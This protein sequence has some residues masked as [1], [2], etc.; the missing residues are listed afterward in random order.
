AGFFDPS[1][2]NPPPSEFLN[3]PFQITFSLQFF[4]KFFLFLL[5]AIIGVSVHRDFKSKVFSILYSFPIQKRDYLLGKFL[6]AFTL[7][8][9][10]TLL[11]G[12]AL[13]IGEHLP[14][15]HAH[16][17]GD[18]RFAGYAQAF[19]VYVLPNMFVYG[20]GVFAVVLLFRNIYAG[21]VSVLLL[22]FLQI[23]TENAF[24][25]KPLLVG[26]LDPFAQNA[27]AYATQFWTLEEKNAQLIP[28]L[29]VVLY[30]RLLW[31]G[32]AIILGGLTYRK[33]E[34]HQHAI[35]TFQINRKS[36]KETTAANATPTNTELT[37]LQQD[38]SFLQQLKNTWRL[39]NFHFYAIVRNWM[40][41]V[42][43]L[44]GLLAVIFALA[45]VTNTG[46]MVLLPLTRIMLAIPAFFFSTIIIL[47]TFVYSGMLVHKDRN[48]EMNQLVDTC[49][50]PN[51]TIFSAHLLAIIKMQIVLLLVML[52]AGIALQIYN[53]YYHFELGLY[54]FHLFVLTFLGLLIWAF[55][56]FFVHH[57]LPNPYLDI[58]LLILAWLGSTALPE[59]GIETKLLAFNA[60]EVL[61]YSDLDGYGNLL[62][63]F[64]LV[65]SYWLVFGLILLLVTYLLYKRGQLFSFKERLFI[66]KT[67]LQRPVQA[68]FATIFL[69]FLTLGF[70][71][72]K[73]EAQLPNTKVENAY[74]Q[75]FE[76]DFETFDGIV[77]PKITDIQL[78]VNL[79]PASNRFDAKGTYT[80]VNKS[81]KAIDTLLLKTGFDETTTFEFDRNHQRIAEDEYVHFYVLKLAEPLQPNDSLRFQFLMQS[82][83][84]NLFQRNSDILNNG[85]FLRYDVFPR[86]GYFLAADDT[87]PEDSLVAR[88]NVQS[89]AAHLVNFETT[90][91]T[92]ADQI[93]IAPGYLQREWS[94]DNRRYF[95]YRT[96]QPIKFLFCLLSGE[97]TVQKETWKGTNLAVYYHPNH[98]Q[99][100]ANMIAGLKAAIDY[101]SQYFSDFQHR[102]ARII[103][104]AQSEGTLATTMANL[105]PMSEIRF[106]ANT[107][108]NSGKIDLA[109]YVTAH[110]LTHQWWGNQVLPARAAGASMLTESI[111]E[112]ITLQIYKQTYG[113]EK[114]LQFLKNQRF[115]YLRGRN[116]TAQAE[117]P[118]FLV[119]T[120]QQYISYGKGAMAFNSLSQYWSE[121]KL[122]KTLQDF[123]NDYQFKAAP[124]PTSIDLLN[125]LKAA[126]PDSLQYLITDYFEQITFYDN[127]IETAEV[128]ALPNGTYALTIDLSIRKY[129]QD[130]AAIDLAL[131]DYI[132]IGIYDEKEALLELK[133]AKVAQAAH[134][135]TLLLD[136]QPSHLVLDPNYLL[137]DKEVEDNVFGLE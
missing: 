83:E 35:T 79:F 30:N 60:T 85:T 121:A 132:E 69:A 116:R 123:L 11:V 10:I 56:A 4:N 118:L 3:A 108:V 43:V 95:E 25:N 22:F 111:T 61:Q 105:I 133:R 126:V 50:T 115:R 74:F 24:A 73:E 18:F 88:Y 49:P 110:E 93:A 77:Q 16:K 57:L 78:E 48:S 107:N 26:L 14:N 66:A 6:S 33:F 54:L 130:D 7:V 127:R 81:K 89:E 46:E 98:Q 87:H 137:I 9:A 135:I 42:I 62:K 52:L 92:S 40:F 29:G 8:I 113:A 84:N 103:E 124:Y 55:A 38:F 37:S 70:F 36:K 59:I 90:I 23:I 45:R 19:L 96:D 67:R 86:F 76:A 109:F 63:G 12:L 80:L 125:H 128:E 32:L 131:N 5:P 15:L 2:S 72:A 44:L 13:F 117:V 120:P 51:W 65:K 28:V 99:N 112:Y 34:L 122:N 39:S 82:E 31:L 21:F 97:Y 100:L 101:N 71:I 27:V 53:G 102:E 20:I 129:R 136:A 68:T 47:L 119:K 64:F 134:Q 1:P 41:G 17:I 104:F 75:Q 94:K 114:A 58:F 91:S 106:I